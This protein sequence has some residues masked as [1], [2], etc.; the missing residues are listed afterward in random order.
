MARRLIDR[1]RI[2]AWANARGV[3]PARLADGPFDQS[4]PGLRLEF[5]GD[6]Q[7]RGAED[8]RLLPISW[9]EWFRTFEK[10]R[11]ALVIDDREFSPA[12]N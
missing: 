8:E 1:E 6:P 4:D 5:L 10:Y 2:I 9:D 3:S 7:D 11:L 12:I